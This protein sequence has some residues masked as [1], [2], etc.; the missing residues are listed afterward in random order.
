M[1]MIRGVQR[2]HGGTFLGLV[3]DP[4]ITL[5][6]ISATIRDVRTSFEFLEFTFGRI[7]NGYL[8]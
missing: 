5:F 6:Y 4:R 7:R 2:Q 1:V 3:W 8:E